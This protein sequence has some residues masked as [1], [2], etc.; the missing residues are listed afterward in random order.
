[1]VIVEQTLYDIEHS[2]AGSHVIA[3]STILIVDDDRDILTA[4]KL[5]LKRQFGKVVTCDQPN[6]LSELISNNDF[7]AI[8]LDMNF[9]PGDSSGAEGI[10]WLREILRQD[11]DAVVVMVTAHAGIN[12]AVEAMKYGAT[13]FIA[14]PWQNEKVV[15]TVS[16]AISLRASRTEAQQLR[17]S[18]EALT[19]ASTASATMLGQS[20]AMQQVMS[21]IRRAGPTDAN[22]LILGE[23]GTGKELAA[24]E[25][26]AQSER[27]SH[28]FMPIDLGSIAENLFESELF[29]HVKG[30]FSGANQDRVGR[31]L[32]ANQGTL[33]LDEIGNIPPA[34][35]AKL[36]TVLEQREVTP[37]GSNKAQKFD[38]RVVAATNMP[39]T[40]LY[41]N[42]TFREDLLFRLNT[43]E[44]DLPALRERSTDIDEIAKHYANFY[45]K[46]YRKPARILSESA[47][48]AARDY[49]WPGNI[50]ELR[51]SIE[52]AV[53][54]AEGDVLSVEDLQLLPSKA[55]NRQAPDVS[56]DADNSTETDMDTQLNLEGIERRAIVKALERHSYNISHTAKELG[57][58]R[59]AL[60]RR[61]EKHGL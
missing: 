39:R 53:I 14:K 38:V 49:G 57:L 60:Y 36:L 25:L 52:R 54:L 20:T 5:L 2:T 42:E 7:D 29:G 12:L 3:D 24:R 26:H 30:A 37:V 16:A 18:N 47:L 11:P 51:H 40:A 45:A 41:G 43:V 27:S 13:D 8:L 28:V 19:S 9:S 55:S 23:N 56:A 31:L 17:Q 21:L 6:A 48:L 35:Q 58:T 22:V 50:R 15:A 4:G 10:Y 46:K 59:A 32:A 33:F 1:M 34:L 61:M 44:I